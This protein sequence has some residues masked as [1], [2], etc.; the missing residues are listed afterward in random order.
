MLPDTGDSDNC[1]HCGLPV[2]AGTSYGLVIEKSFRP[3]CCPGCQAVAGTILETGLGRY[4]QYR[5]ATATTASTLDT[6]LQQQ[7]HL[8]DRTEMQAGFVQHMDEDLSEAVLILEGISCAACIWL[9]EHQLKRLP[10]VSFV[11]VNLS[12]SQV[13]IRWSPK[14]LNLSEIMLTLYR[15]GYPAHPYQVAKEELLA[16]QLRHRFLRQLAVA[17]IG[18]M[19]VVMY[20]VALYAGAFDQ[21]DFAHR[22]FIRWISLIITTPVVFYSAKPFFTAAWRD[23]CNKRPGM[24]VPVSLAILLAYSASLW[25]TLTRGQDV[26]FDSVCMFTFFLLLGRFLEHKAR[27]KMDQAGN[28]LNKLLP[29]SI[30]KIEAGQQS[31]VPVIDLAPG[32][33]ISV[34]AGQTAPV[35]GELI[36]G[37]SSFNESPITGEFMPVEK[38]VGDFIM[39]GSTNTENPVDIKVTQ[40][41]QQMKLAGIVRL[42]DQARASKPAI[43]ILADQVSRWFVTCVLA[44]TGA[45]AYYWYLHDPTKAFWITLSV[46]VVTC[47]CAL[48]LATPAALTAATGHLRKLG[49]LVTA[50][51]TLASLSRANRVIFDKTGTLTCG[52]LELK[53]VEV[54]GGISR[55]QC[56]NLAAALESCSE[57]PIASAFETTPLKP[58][59]VTLHAGQG[60]EGYINDKLYRIGRPDYVLQLAHA[61]TNLFTQPTST[62]LGQWLL[63]GDESGPLAWFEISDRLRDDAS[64]CINKLK[65]LGLDIEILSGDYHHNVAI[66][67]QQLGIKTYRGETSPEG[68]LNHL[69]ALQRSGDHIIMLGDGINDIPVLAAADV[70]IAMTNASDLARASADAVLM[71][72]QLNHLIA[73][74]NISRKTHRIIK[75]NIAWA[76]FYNLLALPLAVLGHIPPWLAAIGMSVSSLVVVLNA[77]RLGKNTSIST[78]INPAVTIRPAATTVS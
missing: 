2:P 21:I 1:Y 4:Y 31:I 15:I 46:L 59:G 9:I 48:S 72:G 38:Q 42:L 61:Q 27:S 52:Q 66:I 14:T 57:H 36:R 6:A 17:G 75:Q 41:G 30:I 16:R 63:L 3:M 32:D 55:H 29:D 37:S 28:Q 10:G 70:S 64:S 23:I 26:Y 11:T 73:A 45:V 13:R 53:R 35:D 78:N 47:P 25:S 5:T 43:A 20:A 50:G 34:K 18:M 49:F 58:Y 71:S 51:H 68:K 19:Q 12:N 60:V 76:L 40:V 8:Y 74:L 56:L 24:D 39:A 62:S 54:V 65:A 33:L 69:R 77:L 22:D 44:L 7:L 67:A